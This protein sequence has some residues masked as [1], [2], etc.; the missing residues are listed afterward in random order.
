MNFFKQK[1]VPYDPTFQFDSLHTI[2]FLHEMEQSCKNHSWWITGTMNLTVF[3]YKE[4]LGTFLSVSVLKPPISLSPY[5]QE[6]FC[7][8]PLHP[9][10]QW[11]ASSATIRKWANPSVWH[12][13]QKERINS[14]LYIMSKTTVQVLLQLYQ[15][16]HIPMLLLAGKH[17]L[18]G[19]QP[20]PWHWA[21]RQHEASWTRPNG[22]GTAGALLPAPGKW[23]CW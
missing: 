4:Q 15:H 20:T 1:T 14:A 21:M 3:M 18:L 16:L 6:P 5:V 8:N 17:S 13:R 11:D 7:L 22:S 12:F 23:Q 10:L 19:H 2:C 9:V